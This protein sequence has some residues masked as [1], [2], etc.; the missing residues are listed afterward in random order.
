LSNF[1]IAKIE[2]AKDNLLINLLDDAETAVSK[3]NKTKSHRITQF[4]S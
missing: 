2:E 1:E 3:N 4:H